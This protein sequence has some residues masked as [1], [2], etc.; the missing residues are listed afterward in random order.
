MSLEHGTHVWE[1]LGPV[2]GRGK[3][4]LSNI[5]LV[6]MLRETQQNGRRESWLQSPSQQYQHIL[7]HREQDW[8]LN[9]RSYTQQ[10]LISVQKTSHGSVAQWLHKH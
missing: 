1:G 3:W 6:L 8:C 9:W 4:G 2:V 7:V 5:A 10:V